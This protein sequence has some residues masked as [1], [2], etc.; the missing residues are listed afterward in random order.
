MTAFDLL[1]VPV[2]GLIAWEDF[3]ERSIHWWLLPLFAAALLIEPIRA[4]AIQSRLF[5]AAFNTVVLTAVCSGAW[6]L[7]CLRHGRWLNPMRD[8]V[9][10]GDL[11][12]LLATAWG[13]PA[14][15]FSAFL[16]TGLVLALAAWMLISRLTARRS[17]TIPLAGLLA[18]HLI[19]WIG[20]IH[21]ISALSVDAAESTVLHHG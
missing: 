18:L 20:F 4:G 10:M 16:I 5:E 14:A 2:L 13:L 7:L 17:T 3:R 9:G 15:E 6:L 11:L 1:A 12:F 21:L 19:A 8:S